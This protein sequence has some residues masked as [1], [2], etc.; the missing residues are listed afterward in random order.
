MPIRKSA[1][2][3]NAP[4]RIN[5]LVTDVGRPTTIQPITSP[6]YATT[7]VMH[8]M[9]TDTGFEPGLTDPE[10]LSA[11]SRL[12]QRVRRR[13]L[14]VA[15]SIAAA[16]VVASGVAWAA[17]LSCPNRTGTLC[18]G[19]DSKDTMTGGDRRADDMRARGGADEMRG[20]GNA[21]SM[22]GQ[23]GG[24]TVL[25]Q[26]GPDALS[27]G[28][29]AD[30]VG[31]GK[32][33]DSLS[34]GEGPDALSGGS[35]DDTYTFVINDWGNDTITDATNSDN[36][37][38]TGNFAVFGF[39]KPLTTRLTIDLTSHANS[40][41]VQNGTLSSKVNWSNNAIDG[42]YVESI[43]DDTINGNASANQLIA[44]GGEDSDDTVNA[45]AGDDWISVSDF[46][47]GDTVDCGE[48]FDTVFF[49]AGDTLTIPANCERQ[50]P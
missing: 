35:A 17:N 20:R 5:S 9:V 40:P 43:T 21:D 37:P 46:A 45:G 13:A 2:T 12:D 50:N 32:G 30:T 3:A 23:P 11:C 26:D 31:G 38:F 41:E 24:D 19:T 14:F 29:G 44:K 15:V 1:I 28:P 42:V 34:G 18:V 49:E 8:H 25:G 27:G 48:G 7:T 47:G 22:L 36:D 4:G 39:P 6:A 10:L 33:K 16:L